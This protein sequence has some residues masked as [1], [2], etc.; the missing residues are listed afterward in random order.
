MRDSRR[1]SVALVVRTFGVLVSASL[2]W[3]S[4][5]IGCGAREIGEA[6]GDQ[7]GPTVTGETPDACANPDT[8]CD[9]A[10]EGATA[11]CGEVKQNVGSYVKCSMGKR[12]CR[13]GRWSIC[14]GELVVTKSLPD[15][16]WSALATAPSSCG[17]NPCNPYCSAY[18]DNPT[19]IDAGTGFEVA[20]GGLRLVGGP[21]T[22][23]GTCTSMTIAPSSTTVT[24]TDLTA[25]P[26]AV[27]FTPTFLPNGCAAAG[28][29][30]TWT[31]SRP[32]LA[33]INASG[34]LTV[35]GAVAGTNILAVKAFFGSLTASA[36]VTVKVKIIADDAS[37]VSPNVATT[38]ATV[39]A[40]YTDA[41]RSTPK[42]TTTASTAVWLYPYDDTHF[43]RGLPSPTLQYRVT[44]SAGSTVKATL[45]Y[46]SGSNAGSALFDY[47]LF[48]LE[49]S[50]V[51][52]GT[53][54]IYDPQ[55]VM[56]QTAW[57]AFAQT[58]KGQDADLIVQR[59]V[60]TTLQVETVQT[61]HFVDAVL[62]GTVWYESYASPIANNTGAILRIDP[63][64]TAP[65]LGIQPRDGSP[66]GTCTVCHSFTNDGKKAFVNGGFPI[67]G[68]SGSC[69]P[70]YKDINSSR[71]YDLTQPYA[72]PYKPAVLK[73]YPWASGGSYCKGD[74]NEFG[75]RFTLAGARTD[76]SLVMTHSSK[77]DSEPRTSPDYSKLWDPMNTTAAKTVSGWTNVEAAF[78]T[79][80]PDGSRLA[81]TFLR[82][83]AISQS[84]SGT[85]ASSTSANVLAVVD[86]TCSAGC[87]SGFTVSNARNLTP[88]VSE[89]VTYPS[90]TPD[91]N[92][93]VYQRHYRTP[94][95]TYGT[96]TQ[97]TSGALSEL[98]M[99]NIPANKNTA[100]TPTRLSALNG[101]TTP[102]GTGTYLPDTAK[103]L[104]ATPTAFHKNGTSVPV[105]DDYCGGGTNVTTT[106]TRLNYYPAF[107]PQS[108]GNYNWVIFTSRRM[109]GNVAYG[110][111]WSGALAGSACYVN[112]PTKKLW[113]AAVDKNFTPGTDPSHPAFYL[114]GQELAAGNS[115]A[116]W[117]QSPC[118]ATGASCD[119]TSDCCQSPAA[120]S[121]R[122][123]VGSGPPTTR[124]CQLTSSCVPTS[125][126]CDVDADCCGAPSVKCLDNI[127]AGGGV[128]FETKTYSR[129]YTAACPAGSAVVWQTFEWQ[130][131]IPNAS[132]TISFTAQTATSSGAFGAAV[133]IGTA[134]TTVTAPSWATGPQTVDT[135]LR[136]A[137]QRSLARLRVNMTFN[138]DGTGTATLNNWRQLYDCVPAE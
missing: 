45:R 89:R 38:A 35:Q 29:Q 49:R 106:E 11:A 19:G 12:T 73:D 129:D 119:E 81:F 70:N 67:L 94:W 105:K 71:L 28:T 82:G 17:T 24:V 100:A 110:N 130:A 112:P 7:K 86:F 123:D 90:F 99:S 4:L 22:N 134:S 131:S 75:D 57:D 31:V 10:D 132:S 85:L 26:A 122:I 61:I 58:A 21:S 91:G 48:A 47:S 18:T 30:P 83:T 104:P 14:E 37:E 1:S 44:N 62:K 124:S 42:S 32:D 64:A 92:A 63:N 40:F 43:P 55:V 72:G 109:Y 56:P 46:P 6:D 69:L 87:T 74:Q 107:M 128:A 66:T 121:C 102:T 108:T 23:G 77:T 16:R 136:A 133:P 65:T 20:D 117:V 138:T 33:V 114:P 27:T 115:Q 51:Y 76:G 98:W 68:E 60:G 126:E 118:R 36:N 3:G 125:G 96:K 13:D 53:A 103:T 80:S 8:G 137:S 39:N 93:V 59:Y 88:S 2:V 50:V 127:C 5:A 15:L 135:A 41:T 97:S 9:C 95:A 78:P 111:P 113:I 116:R 79:F 25:P 54:N 101:Y 84:P 52:P 34:S 120:Q